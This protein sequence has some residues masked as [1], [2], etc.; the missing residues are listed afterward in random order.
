MNL[1][2]VVQ[3]DGGALKLKTDLIEK[4]WQPIIEPLPL[5]DSRLWALPHVVG[6]LAQAPTPEI[7][8]GDWGTLPPEFEGA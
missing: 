3:G 6:E 1:L 5:E 7:L 4:K 8:D 2:T